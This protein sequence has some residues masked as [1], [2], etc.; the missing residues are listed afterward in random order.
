M[1]VPALAEFLELAEAWLAERYPKVAANRR[2]AW[3]EGRYEVRVF[4]EPDP[5]QEAD[6]LPAIRA[7]RQ[8]LWG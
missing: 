1:T 3:G 5:E 8:E 7:W 2:F 4:Q 6:A